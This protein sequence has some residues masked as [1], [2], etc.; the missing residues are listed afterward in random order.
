MEWRKATYSAENGNCVEVA[1]AGSVL[2]RDT[3]DRAGVTLSV[4]AQAWRVRRRLVTGL[5]NLRWR[6]GVVMAK[7]MGG[8]HATR[9]RLQLNRGATGFDFGGRSKR[10]ELRVADVTS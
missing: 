2:I 3:Q 7:I 6:F 10:S 5:G 8:G 1:S 4:P 9:G